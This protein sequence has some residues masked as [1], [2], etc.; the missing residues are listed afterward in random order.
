MEAGVIDV[1]VEAKG[2]GFV[3]QRTGD[4]TNLFLHISEIL[5][6]PKDEIPQCGDVVLF[7]QITEPGQRP[8][9]VRALLVLGGEDSSLD[10]ASGEL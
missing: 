6:C 1:W 10:D 4:R 7:D 8:K 2:Y 5:N 3:K 9:A